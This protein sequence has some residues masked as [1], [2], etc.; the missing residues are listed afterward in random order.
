MDVEPI[1]RPGGWILGSCLV[2]NQLAPACAELQC[3]A[4]AIEWAAS[5]S[6]VMRE[7]RL[8]R[9]TGSAGL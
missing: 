5:A 8:A 3:R 2:V 7:A 9:S 6:E 1:R 4:Y